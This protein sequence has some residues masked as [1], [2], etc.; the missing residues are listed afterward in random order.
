MLTRLSG[1]GPARSARPGPDGLAPVDRVRPLLQHLAD[2][3][4]DAEG[5]ARRPVPVLGAHAVGDQLAVLARDLLATDPPP[6]ALA[7]LADRLV[8]LR[9]AL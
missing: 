4:A 2:A 5:R 8:A 9:R 3:A 1:L 7:D 6:G